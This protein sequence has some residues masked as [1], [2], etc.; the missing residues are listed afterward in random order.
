MKN[1]TL[2]AT[3]RDIL[4]KKTRFLRRQG[5]TPTHLLGRGLKSLALQCDTAELG[6]IIMLGGTT[7]LIDLQIEAE[8]QPRSVFIREIQ[9]DNI[10]EQLLHVD[11]YQV[12]KEDKITAD[13]P[14]A[15]IGEAPAIKSKGN[16][17]QQILAHLGVECLPEKLP[18]RIEIDLSP[19]EEIDQAIHVRDIALGT[20]VTITTA[21]DQ[22]VV[23]VSKVHI[24]RV[25]EKEVVAE[26]IEAGAEAAEAGTPTEEE[27]KG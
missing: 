13:V 22:L 12:R 6:H 1:L 4:G 10:S 15:L 2:E 7:R 25:E 8:K 5:I 26:E 24:E 21:P 16:T 11:F 19:L 18:P 23:K 3:K 14:I 27:P 17:L 20:D 9:R